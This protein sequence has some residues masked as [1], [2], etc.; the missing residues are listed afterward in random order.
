MK[1]DGVRASTH[2]AI[3]ELDDLGKEPYLYTHALISLKFFVLFYGMIFVLWQFFFGFYSKFICIIMV[4]VM[5]RVSIISCY[6]VIFSNLTMWV[7]FS[8]F[9]FEV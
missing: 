8:S 5:V 4:M 3:R 7:Y 9:L 2:T 1:W 6:E